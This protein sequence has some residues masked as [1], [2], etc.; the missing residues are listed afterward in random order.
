MEYRIERDTLGEMKVP[1]DRLWGA[2]T[3]RSKENFPIGN[4]QMPME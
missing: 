1:A 3:Q 4:E 2:Q